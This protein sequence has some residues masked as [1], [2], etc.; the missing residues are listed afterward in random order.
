[1]T[2]P[3]KVRLFRV[4]RD[5][6]QGAE[7]PSGVS[8][9]HTAMDAPTPA[10]AEPGPTPGEGSVPPAAPQDQPE[11]PAAAPP[12]EGAEAP[13]SR[14]DLGENPFASED[15]GFGALRLTN[16]TDAPAHPDEAAG[17]EVETAAT[18]AP[19]QNP[20]MGDVAAAVLAVK[21][22]GLTSR[23][24]RT[25]SRLAIQHSI[26]VSS[27]EE[28][29][30]RLRRMGI[31]PF[32]RS[33]LSDLISEE[34]RR[35][36]EAAR[37]DDNS[38]AAKADAAA[39]GA[40]SDAGGASAAGDAGG[41]GAGGA[42]DDA[43]GDAASGGKALAR[44]PVTKVPARQA[45][46]NAVAQ[47]RQEAPAP[48]PMPPQPISEG[49]RA[50]EI[51]RIQRDI[52]RRRRRRAFFLFL[53]LLAF[54]L[55][56]T[57]LTGYYYYRIATP[58]Y[59]TNTEFVIQKADGSSGSPLGSM[60]AGAGIAGNTDSITVQ[61]YL[62]SRVAMLR[63]EGD[64]GFRKY[65]EGDQVDP[66]TRLTPESSSEEAYKSY[67][68]MVKIG[69]DP[70]EGI[71]RMAVKAVDPKLSQNQSLA[72]IG[73]A[74]EQVDKLTAR[75]RDDQMKGAQDNYK[76]TEDKMNAAQQRVL[77]LQK[78]LGVLD[79]TAESGM[80]MSR[81]GTMETELQKKRLELAQLQSNAQPNAARV[82]G[83]KG[84]IARLQ[85][86]IDT[87]RALL[88]ETA[89]NKESLAQITGELRIAEA[90]LVTRQE[91]L[92]TAAAEVEAARINANKQVRYLSLGVSPVPPDVPTWPRAFEN[93]LIA[94]LLFSGLYLM[95]SLTASILREQLSS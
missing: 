93:T 84:D 36:R 56:P 13:R 79:P 42:G 35:A 59:E 55:I 14:L 23:Q 77:D 67:S 45:R 7:V 72:L 74:E 33:A 50:K 57:A 28:A 86:A 12:P 40:A 73:Y 95:L 39:T 54:V 21:A 26:Q 18:G 37:G 11:A 51:L 8:D 85:T 63:L 41:S 32:H 38:G 65:L 81:I 89:N 70:S 66:L 29:V 92:A 87:E 30:V 82:A 34:A 19:V 71:I 27:S 22:E 10:V 80:V 75:L 60:L 68:T 91:M 44:I 25:A 3:P 31:D 48:Q 53:R 16:P 4:K 94:F 1:M 76:T 62:T 24:L 5:S 17:P 20:D 46:P 90:D 61:S 49:E 15:D 6:G 2:T 58:L 64:V 83:V 52:A 69:F 9:D 78:K 47:M 88:T 43:P